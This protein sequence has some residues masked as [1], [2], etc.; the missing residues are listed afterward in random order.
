MDSQEPASGIYLYCLAQAGLLKDLAGPGLDGQ[1]ALEILS[2]RGIAAV[3]SRVLLHEFCGADASG[4]MQ[5]L[6]W[7][8]PRACRHEQVVVEVMAQSPVLPVRFGTIFSSPGKLKALLRRHH[9]TIG[10]FLDYV[11]G[12][13]EWSLKVMIDRVEAKE[14]VFQ[15]HLETEASH[16]A[17][18]APGRRYFEEQKLRGKADQELHRWLQE[19]CRELLQDLKGLNQEIR[20]RRA[21][22]KAGSGD[23]RE[24][25]LNLA[26]M[27]PREAVEDLAEFLRAT[28]ARYG[29]RGM[30][31]NLS[32]PWPP[33]SFTPSLTMEGET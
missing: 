17:G 4:H 13:E 24:Q 11:S 1:D 31:L 2:C 25:I 15:R 8:A 20:Q 16:L 26:L 27:M 5:D 32:G 12:R 10:P 23:G 21:R 7:V 33:Y 19:V 29:P 18:L 3:W 30:N 14:A 9:D 28:N 6:S 22:S